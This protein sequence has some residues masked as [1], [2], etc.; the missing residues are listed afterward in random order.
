MLF[1]N[2]YR[3]KLQRNTFLNSEKLFVMC[4]IVKE[5]SSMKY[6][7]AWSMGIRSLFNI[8]MQ[9]IIQFSNNFE[10]NH[11]FDVYLSYKKL[12]EAIH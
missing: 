5:S 7:I 8:Y 6:T 4:I 9:Q 1:I 10:F 12:K 2:K 3:Y 11:V